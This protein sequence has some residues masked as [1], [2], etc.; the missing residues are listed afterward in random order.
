MPEA[1][2]ALILPTIPKMHLYEKKVQV[3]IENA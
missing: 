1:P 3:D 2:F